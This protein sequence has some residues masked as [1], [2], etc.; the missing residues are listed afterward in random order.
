MITNELA[1]AATEM[2]EIL[3]YLPIEYVEKVPLKLRKFLKKIE[4]TNYI[5]DITPYKSLKE[6]NL[7]P[8][9]KNLLIIIYRNYWCT[10]E[11]KDRIDSI[12]MENDKKYE[13]ELIEKYNPN[14]IFKDRK[15]QENIEVNLQT[16]NENLPIEYKEKFYQKFINFI[17]KILKF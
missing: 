14:D 5:A 11:E 6:Q 12:L 3:K 17:K 10:N 4:K 16:K 7:K 9:T 2:N 1:E 8:K 15:K 13:K